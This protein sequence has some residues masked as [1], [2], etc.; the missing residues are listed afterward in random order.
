MGIELLTI[1]EFKSY[2]KDVFEKLERIIEL[3][4]DENKPKKW[5][6]NANVK[7]DYGISVA[8]SKRRGI[9]EK[10]HIVELWELFIIYKK[11]SNLF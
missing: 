5:L 8:N 3:I 1:N 6:K 7:K 9:I 10:F 11:I 2:K 4:Q